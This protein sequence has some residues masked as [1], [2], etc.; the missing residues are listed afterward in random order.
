MVAILTSAVIECQR[1]GLKSS[2]FGFAAMLLR[3]EYRQ[4]IDPKWKK[5]IEQIVR[6][7][8]VYPCSAAQQHDLTNDRVCVCVYCVCVCVCVCV[9]MYVCVC[10]CVNFSCN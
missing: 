6:F 5:R 7:V 8:R 2:C 4:K 3:P 1:S 10:V 9:Y